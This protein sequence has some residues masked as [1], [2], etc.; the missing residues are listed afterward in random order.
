MEFY[1]V[2]TRQKVDIPEN[3]LRKRTIVQKSGKHTYAVTGEENGTKLVRF[4]SKQQYDALQVPET[5][6]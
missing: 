1:N 2:K 5:E 6:G 3:D 4:V